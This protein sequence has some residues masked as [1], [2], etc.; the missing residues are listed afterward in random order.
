MYK[1]KFN[2]FN[3]VGSMVLCGEYNET[4]YNNETYYLRYFIKELK[5]ILGIYKGVSLEKTA[6]LYEITDPKNIILFDNDQYY[7]WGAYM[8]NKTY[9]LVPAGIPASSNNLSL[10]TI[11]NNKLFFKI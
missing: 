8:Y 11:V 2:S 10:Q 5:I 3:N 4:T 6:S 7:L 1:N 9:T